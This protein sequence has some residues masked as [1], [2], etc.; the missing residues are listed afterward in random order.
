ME[1]DSRRRSSGASKKPYLFGKTMSSEVSQ[2]KLETT[3]AIIMDDL[4][5]N[6]GVG[7]WRLNSWSRHGDSCARMSKSTGEQ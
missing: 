7:G 6:G 2:L 4:D 3:S 5:G 1:K